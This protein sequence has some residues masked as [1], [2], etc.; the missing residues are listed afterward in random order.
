MS[1]TYI[2]PLANQQWFLAN[3][4]PA[5]GAQLFFYL[6]GTTTK[7]NTWQDVAGAVANANP[8][9]LDAGGR[10]PSSAE[11][12]FTG[13]VSYKM[14]FAPAN[15]SDPPASPYLTYDSL[16]GINDPGFPGT[17]E[18]IASGLTPTYL[19]VTSFS[20]PGDQRVALPVGQRVQTNNSG[21]TVYGTVTTATF[22]AN[23]TTITIAPDSGS[24]DNGLSVVN[25]SIQNA[26][27]LSTPGS[28]ARIA[29]G[30]PRNR[31]INGRF[32]IDEYRNF[33]AFTPTATGYVVDRWLGGMTAA[34]KLT[35]QTI[36]TTPPS[37][38]THW[39]RI[40]VASQFNPGAADQFN[41]I[42]KIEGWNIADFGLGIASTAQSFT[43]SFWA[44]A[45]V[46]GTYA[47]A[48]LNAAN[49]RS[50]VATYTIAQANVAQ[51]FQL[52]VPCDITGTWAIDSTAGLWVVFDL[53]S[54]SNFVTTANAWQSGT[55]ATTAGAVK[56]V[57]QVNNSTLDIAGV[58]LELGTYATPFEV[59]PFSLERSLCQYYAHV[60]NPLG[61]TSGWSGNAPAGF[62]TSTT[63]GYVY[64]R[65]PF[66]MRAA[67]T[68]SQIGAVGDWSAYDGTNVNALTVIALS[69]A[70]PTMAQLQVTVA[71]G[72]IQ[73]RPIIIYPSSATGKMLFSA[74]L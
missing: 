27:N 56:F 42:Q 36:T 9:V 8:I 66:P 53:G 63:Q 28:I 44:R 51:Y 32:D 60:I 65:S 41:F 5:A 50:Y 74:E 40:K 10:V 39:H 21:G 23:A 1:T 13:G 14:V 35:F 38:F 26:A 6:A 29:S 73:Y 19:S 48:F 3:G 59:R 62:G 70:T 30:A 69:G 24:L 33:A 17:S 43:L 31:I 72:L 2:A 71:A 25:L 49:N 47:V 37:G 20:V 54:G 58:Q 22:A 11:V 12:R 7:S 67:P 4:T 52:T 57:N 34:S 64:V 18:W 55:F 16:T 15:D 68:L 61:G 46:A 45:S